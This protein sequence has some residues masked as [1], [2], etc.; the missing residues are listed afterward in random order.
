M[1]VNTMY[2]SGTGTTEK[3]T[4]IIARAI[5][6]NLNSGQVN[7]INITPPHA[8]QEQISFSEQDL[9]VIGVPVIAGRV[10]NVLVKFLR[11]IR[12]NGAMAIAVVVYGNRNYDDALVELQDIVAED[13][14]KVM[15]A[16]A[17]IG[18]HSFSRNLAGERPDRADLMVMNDFAQQVH[19]KIT[20]A[21]EIQPLWVKGQRPYRDYYRPKNQAGEPV[22]FRSI[23][24][25]TNHECNN[26]LICAE[27]C[28]MGS[29]DRDD[30]SRLTGICIKCCACIKKCPLKARYFDDENFL[31]H[32]I[33]L[34]IQY[35]DRKEPE[36]FI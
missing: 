21:G 12:G 29:I 36:I 15:A 4:S 14:F 20:S 18:E 26:C 35:A 33:E 17:F 16:G 23:S 34:E 1:I 30:V 3:T 11:T 6:R 31:R 27:V 22:D 7:K 2:F 9:V 19:H 25:K 5:A 28:P 10:P 8:R 24:P 13:G 32:K